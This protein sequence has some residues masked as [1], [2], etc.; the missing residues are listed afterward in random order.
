MSALDDLSAE[1]VNAAFTAIVTPV[2]RDVACQCDQHPKRPCT[3]Q[4]EVMVECHIPGQCSGPE[5]NQFGNRVELL[6]KPCARHLW[7]EA[8]EMADDARARA[9]RTGG[10]AVCLSCLAPMSQASDWMR[11]VRPI[12]TG[13][14]A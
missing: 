8:H 9:K 7:R 14:P 3:N 11:S 12:P 4:A 5:A 10:R 13:G 2:S 6:C 1:Q